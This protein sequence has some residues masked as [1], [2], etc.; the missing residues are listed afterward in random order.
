[1]AKE[2]NVISADAE[3]IKDLENHSALTI[4]GICEDDFQV[5]LN[6]ISDNCGGLKDGD[7]YTWS[8]ELFNKIYKLTKSNAY[9]KDLHFLC[10]PNDLIED[11]PRMAIARFQ[12]GGRW[13]DDI[14]DNNSRREKENKKRGK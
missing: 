8:G 4:E 7:V 10:I 11:M 14:C 2:W 6:W 5:A 12:F 3:K 1:M 9:P 13:L